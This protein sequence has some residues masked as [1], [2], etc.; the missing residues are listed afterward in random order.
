MPTIIISV[1]IQYLRPVIVTLISNVSVVI[2][3]IFQY[4][5]LENVMPGKR[6]WIEIMGA[7]LCFVGCSLVPIGQLMQH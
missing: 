4:T 3:L 2:M 7:V 6:N 1:L 5:I